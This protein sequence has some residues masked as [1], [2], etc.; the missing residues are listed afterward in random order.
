MELKKGR[1]FDNDVDILNFE[2][3]NPKGIE[4]WADDC[5]VSEVVEI[6][7]NGREII[8]LL[9]EIETPLAMG[10]G[11]IGIA[12]AYGHLTPK[13]LYSELTDLEECA[14]LCCGDCGFIGC[15]S[16]LVNVEMDERYVYWKEFRNNHRDWEYNISYK[17]DRL[18]YE[19]VLKTI[20]S[21]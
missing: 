6:Y 11:H 2:I 15:W 1:N 21:V 9:R 5:D 4:D 13:Q 17:F 12:G 18:E 10:E 8:E 19:N 20:A 3:I 14:L 16:V 7:I